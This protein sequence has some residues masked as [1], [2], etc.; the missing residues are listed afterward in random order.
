M[1]S[2]ALLAV[3]A[4]AAN[5]VKQKLADKSHISYS[6]HDFSHIPPHVCWPT[7]LG[8]LLQ[9][10]TNVHS[11]APP[12]AIPGAMNCCFSHIPLQH[13]ARIF[14]KQAS[15][16]D[17]SRCEANTDYLAAA[18]VLLLLLLTFRIV[19]ICC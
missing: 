12:V 15:P 5:Q 2:V 11:P 19:A 14:G 7:Y 17:S 18:F 13:A 16:N 3:A 6:C 8:D 9:V 4:N 10:T 1:T